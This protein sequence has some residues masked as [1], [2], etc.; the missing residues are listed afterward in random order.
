MAQQL[1]RE[2]EE[3]FARSL[4]LNH[5]RE[6]QRQREYQ[7]YQQ[8]R[9]RQL[10]EMSSQNQSLMRQRQLEDDRPRIIHLSN[11]RRHY[12]R[13]QLSP[14]ERRDFDDQYPDEYFSEADVLEETSQI[15]EEYDDE[16]YHEADE[17]MN[18]AEA[19]Q[20]EQ[21]E[22]YMQEHPDFLLALDIAEYRRQRDHQI[23]AQQIARSP[24]QIQM[25]QPPSHILNEPN[26][27]SPPTQE[28]ASLQPTTVIP[29]QLI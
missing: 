6:M 4:L 24:R 15:P 22:F 26:P 16:M 12:L 23:L 5:Y 13:Q 25:A 1:Q 14:Q 2:E 20:L 28:T 10:A 21:M 11:I 8:Q 29:R 19:T 9:R 7:N 3:Q 18:E 17:E 27:S